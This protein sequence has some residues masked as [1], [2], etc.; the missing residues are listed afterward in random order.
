[1]KQKD[2][3]V[4]KVINSTIFDQ[5]KLTAKRSSSENTVVKI[6][7]VK[8]GGPKITVIAGPCSVESKDQLSSTTKIV[9]KNGAS[10]LRGGA[11][12]PRTSPYSFQGL[13]EKGIELLKEIGEKYDIPVVSEVMDTQKVAFVSDHVDILQVGSRNMHNTALLEEVG[14]SQKPVLLKRGMSATVEEFLFAAEYIMAQG[15][16]NVILCER[17]IRTFE[18]T[19]RFTLDINAIPMLKNISHL[20]VIVDPSHGTGHWW[21]VPDLAKAAIAAGADG[22]IIEV[23]NDPVNALCDGAQS[24][25]PDTFKTLMQELTHVAK[26]VGREI[27][28]IA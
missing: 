24:L 27:D 4:H 15:N 18:P 17:G 7:S 21:M 25:G 12:K 10:I 26:A 1:M 22:L 23:H 16:K 19:S 11:F 2:I 5:L 14:K 28:A 3:S 9:K 13:R 20:P 6:G 8:I